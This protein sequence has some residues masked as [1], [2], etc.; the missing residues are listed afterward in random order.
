MQAKLP[1]HPWRFEGVTGSRT[2]I[3]LK[4]SRN[5]EIWSGP[6]LLPGGGV[7]DSPDCVVAYAEQ[8]PEGIPFGEHAARDLPR[9][10]IGAWM[11]LEGRGNN[12][13]KG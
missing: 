3:G 6:Q 1:L 11:I 10:Q 7:E 9:H 5:R 4:I 12:R 13:S 8:E 2:S